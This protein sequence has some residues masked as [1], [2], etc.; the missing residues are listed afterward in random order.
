M[1]WFR[2]VRNGP[3]WDLGAGQ[4]N[5]WKAAGIRVSRAEARGSKWTRRD[6]AA[7]PVTRILAAFRGA[8]PACA[9]ESSGSLW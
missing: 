4:C 3:A 6:E 5:G 8:H 9:S 1:H 2:A 7:F